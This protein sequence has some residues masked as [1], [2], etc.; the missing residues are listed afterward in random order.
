MTV[1]QVPHRNADDGD[2]DDVR[3]RQVIADLEQLDRRLPAV[4]A[5]E[6]ASRQAVLAGVRRLS[7]PFD[8]DA[9]PTHVTGSALVVGPRGIV[10][11][12]HKRLGLWLQ[13]GGHLDPHEWPHEAALREAQEETGL[14]V[15]HPAEGPLLLHVDA[16]AG[17]RGHRHLDLRYV[18]HVT[19]DVDPTPPAGESQDCRWVSFDE[20]ISMAD[21]G[22]SGALPRLR[23]VVEG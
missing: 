19:A 17:G 11:H 1:D 15:V 8:E 3:R 22:L 4:D 23:T 5:R 21:A 12:L 2:G 13:P 10:L 18:L 6:V 14:P 16:H 7:A 20:A 9:D